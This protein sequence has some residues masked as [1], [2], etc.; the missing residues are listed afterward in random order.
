MD[1]TVYSLEIIIIVLLGELA[2]VPIACC[3]RAPLVPRGP[4][5]SQPIAAAGLRRFSSAA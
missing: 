4:L 3:A 2:N 5:S 1:K